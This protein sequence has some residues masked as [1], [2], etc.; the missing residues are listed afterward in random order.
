MQLLKDSVDAQLSQPSL[1]LLATRF[2]T[3]SQITYAERRSRLQFHVRVRLVGG[4]S[5]KK[6][7][8]VN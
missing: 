3:P 5:F 6:L 8:N 7:I 1:T 4:F 2:L